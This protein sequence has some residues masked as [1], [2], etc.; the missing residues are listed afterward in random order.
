[1]PT[2]YA[3]AVPT[4]TGDAQLLDGAERF[5]TIVIGGGQA[6]PGLA[7]TLDERGERVALVNHGPIGGTCL[8]DGCRPTKAMRASARV[9]HLARRARRWGVETG[10]VT[11]DLAA[12]VARKD[13]MIGTWRDAAEE[14]YTD[15]PSLTYLHG[16]ARFAGSVTRGDRSDDDGDQ[17]GHGAGA[18]AGDGPLHVVDVTTD[19][20]V[21]RLAARRVILNTGARSVPPP[22]DGL[23]AIPWLD[24]HSILDLT[25]LPS[26]LVVIGGSYIGL[27]FGQMFARF[28]SEVTIVEQGPRLIGREDVDVTDAI[29]AMLAD[30]D[31]D[32]RTGTGIER[33]TGGG[34][35]IRV[36]LA[37]G[38]VIDASHVLVAAGRIPNSDDLG[39]DT[40]GVS[41]DERGYVTTDDVFATDV[42]GIYAVGDVNGRGAFT[43]TSYQDFEILADHLA[44]G[45]RTVAGRTATYALFTDP[46]LGR[47]GIT[48]SQ[49]IERGI[50][51][52]VVTFPASELTKAVLDGETHGL[53]RLVVDDRSG[54]FLG[55]AAFALHGDEIV[56]IVSMMMHAGVRA[57]AFETWLPIHPTVAEFLPTIVGQ[58]QPPD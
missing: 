16:W 45:D 21:R 15:D 34:G 35:A 58:L 40:V 28:G 27:E 53:I 32:V 44:G 33:I 49:A 24:H 11:V 26:R 2:H 31:I 29:E 13:E 7:T 55:A 39:L 52:S 20:G 5:D 4:S 47:V 42:A 6:G 51:H 37:G 18:G 38:D 23:D 9:A 30:E 54:Q 36:E 10:E 25:E 12:V 57:D 50:D 8:N 48:E 43:H 19:D 22:I 56:Q 41:R 14:S 46:P 3:R 1:M 17:A